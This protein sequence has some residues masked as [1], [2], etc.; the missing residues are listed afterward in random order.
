LHPH[1]EE[2]CHLQDNIKEILIPYFRFHRAYKDPLRNVVM[3]LENKPQQLW[4]KN[5]VYAKF[6]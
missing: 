1:T 5:E 3:V 2:D 6:I 4:Y